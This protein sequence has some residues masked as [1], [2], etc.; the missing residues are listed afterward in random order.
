MVVGS[1]SNRL[2]VVDWIARHPE[3]QD[4]RI[5]APIVVIGMFRAGTTFLSQLLDQDPRNR[6]LLLWEAGDSVPP[7]TPADHRAGPRVDAVHAS[8]AML[9]EI[10]PQIEAI[11]HEEADEATEC[12][13]VM[14]QDFK[15]LT[16]E[17][18]ANVPAYGDW[19]LGVDQR[20]AYEYHRS[21]LQV[22]QSGGVRGR[23]TLK[24]PHHAIALE[25]LA[26][27]YPD[28][29]LVLLH[30]DPVVLSASVCSLIST[31]S[32]TF[33]DADHRAYI[34]A[35]WPAMLEESVRRIDAFRA[36]HPE[37]PIV[38]VQYA[39]L[40]TDPA[41]TVASIYRAVGD[42]LDD[43]GAQ[44]RRRVRRRPS[45]RRVR[46]PPLRRG[47]VR[48]RRRRPRRALRRLHRPLR[49]PPRARPDP[50]APLEHACARRDIVRVS[51]RRNSVAARSA[52]EGEGEVADAGVAVAAGPLDRRRRARWRRSAA[53]SS[54]Y[55]TRI[56][57]RA[58]LAPRQ[59][60]SPWPK[61]RCG[62][63]SRRDVERVGG[64][65]GELVA[66]GRA[67]PDHDL[68]ARAR[69]CDRRARRSRWRCGASTV[70]AC[71]QRRISSIAVPMQ[72]GV[73]AQRDELVG[74]VERA[75]A[76]RPRWRC[77]SS[78]CRPRTAG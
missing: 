4:E 58:R 29:R 44:G 66:V 36:A 17:A 63:G 27:V 51:R 49:H 39:D 65:E 22:L 28:A 23:W 5:D 30:R 43:T 46:R 54:S 77:G 42:E 2:R 11:H 47:R 1:L 76:A 13:A 26:A 24:S 62:L 6:A 3:V 61:P 38:D 73:G 74:M 50:L 56:S 69:W 12:I 68:L 35:H 48:P 15:S 32:S 75:R 33:T 53:S 7:P 72:R 37:H 10:N 78:R 18:I 34:V 9:A 57:R 21:V 45:A 67:L 64:R 70:T 14:G 25:H 8:N 31:L 55:I 16:W 40:V 41:A 52:G 19:L 71:V 59:K 20:S 60:C